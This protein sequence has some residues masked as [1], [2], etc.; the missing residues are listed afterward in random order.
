VVVVVGAVV[1]VVVGAVV[2]T[3]TVEVVVTGTA[4]TVVSLPVTVPEQ[5]AMRAREMRCHS[6]RIDKTIRLAAG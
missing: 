6:R 1:V 4:V 3:T 5:A 2:V